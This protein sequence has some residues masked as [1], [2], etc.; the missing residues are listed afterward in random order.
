M[1]GPA[2]MQ[3]AAQTFQSATNYKGEM[4][5]AAY[6]MNQTGGLWTNARMPVAASTIQQAIL[7][8]H[9]PERDGRF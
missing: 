7:V 9:G 3:L 6:A 4:S 5:A 2:T 8:P 1:V